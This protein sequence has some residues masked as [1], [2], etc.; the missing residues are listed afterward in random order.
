[1]ASIK[2]YVKSVL[3]VDEG[4]YLMVMAI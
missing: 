3:A 4:K 2:T 1:M